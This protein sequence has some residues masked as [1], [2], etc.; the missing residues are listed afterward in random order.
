MSS[1]KLAQMIVCY[2]EVDTLALAE[3]QCS[4]HTR[5]WC[6]PMPKFFVAIQ[7]ISY[8]FLTQHTVWRIW[9]WIRMYAKH[10]IW[11][12]QCIDKDEW[13]WTD[14]GGRKGPDRRN[15]TN[16]RLT[17][18]GWNYN[19]CQMELQ[20]TLNR[21]VRKVGWNYDKRRMELRQMLDETASAI[22]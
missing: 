15:W 20:Q 21:T 2:F 16:G 18:I 1:K 5:T 9:Y 19:G 12:I 14:V 3:Q 22:E 4:H 7:S 6:C 8:K 11:K 13:R 10:M 17:N